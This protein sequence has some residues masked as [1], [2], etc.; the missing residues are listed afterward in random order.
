MRMLLKTLLLLAGLTSFFTT[1]PL[2]AQP[3]W[4]TLK[5]RS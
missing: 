4:K 5:L 3:Y 2:L 1:N